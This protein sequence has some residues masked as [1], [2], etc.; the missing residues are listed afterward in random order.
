M[1]TGINR[2]TQFDPHLVGIVVMECFGHG[3]AQHS[4]NLHHGR[5]THMLCL[6]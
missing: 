3:V 1:L 5:K 6:N 4:Y 2:S